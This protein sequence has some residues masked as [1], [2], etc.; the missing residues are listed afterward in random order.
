MFCIWEICWQSKKEVDG[1][2]VK[3]KQVKAVGE[4]EMAGEK[5]RS[6]KLKKHEFEE[7]TWI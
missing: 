4:E 7:P 3:G 1:V 6:E 2:N 5:E